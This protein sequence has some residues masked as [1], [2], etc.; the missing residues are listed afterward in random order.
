MPNITTIPKDYI[1]LYFSLEKSC[2]QAVLLSGN[3]GKHSK[4]HDISTTKPLSGVVW[5]AKQA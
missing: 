2:H 5:V 3:L 1:K 4:N